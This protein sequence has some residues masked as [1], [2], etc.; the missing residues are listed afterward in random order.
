MIIPPFFFSL[1]R[2]RG[3][4]WWTIHEKMRGRRTKEEENKEKDQ[5]K[6]A[7]LTEKGLHDGD[8][9]LTRV[10]DSAILRPRAATGPWGT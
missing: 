5:K 6:K 7:K 4:T 3:D 10:L 2:A 9:R 1:S 8:Y